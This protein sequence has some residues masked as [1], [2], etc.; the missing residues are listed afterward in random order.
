[1]LADSITTFPCIFPSLGMCLLKAYHFSHIA[2]PRQLKPQCSSTKG[3][4]ESEGTCRSDCRPGEAATGCSAHSPPPSLWT[5]TGEPPA[6]HSWLPQ[7]FRIRGSYFREG[8]LPAVPEVRRGP[9]RGRTDGLT[10]FVP[11]PQGDLRFSSESGR[12][13]PNVAAK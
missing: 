5:P 9:F 11:G 7:L 6:S 10:N 4:P 13:G 2:T 1:M 12:P 3:L 8:P